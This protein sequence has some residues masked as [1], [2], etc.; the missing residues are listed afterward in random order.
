[1]NVD[2]PIPGPVRSM[3]I[4]AAIGATAG[5]G[6]ALAATLSAERVHTAIAAALGASAVLAVIHLLSREDEP[7]TSE[8]TEDRRGLNDQFDSVMSDVLQQEKK[9][10]SQRRRMNGAIRQRTAELMIANREL[11]RRDR[12]RDE[13]ISLLAHEFRTPLTS[14]RS[15]V[16]LLLRHGSDVAP[17]ER[18]QFLSIVSAQVQRLGLLIN[19]LLNLSRLRTGRLDLCIED[20]QVA[21]VIDE[22][23][24]ATR[25]MDVI[26]NKRILIQ[27]VPDDALVACDRDR[28]VEILLKLVGNSLKYTPED[29]RIEVRCAVDER[30]VSFEVTDN[31]P[32]VPE[33]DR[34]LVFEPFYRTRA[35]GQSDQEG[36]GL[37]LY[38]CREFARRMEGNLRLESPGDNGGA[39]FTLELPVGGRSE[40]SVT[41]RSYAPS[42]PAG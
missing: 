26:A 9:L 42:A 20:H 25:A 3:S 17:T 36:T 4:C 40:E 37:G 15:Y 34:D 16:D 28:L 35:I 32:G 38:L 10:E 14:V 39:R 31:G 23:G 21:E 27:G 1:M 33:E 18:Q 11:E 30:T 13:F 2:D 41:P 24:T 7:S 19:D 5:A 8:V 12:L 29:A 6:V 22:L